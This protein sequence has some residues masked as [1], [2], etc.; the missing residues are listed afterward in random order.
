MRSDVS[1]SLMSITW[2]W[3][4]VRDFSSRQLPKAFKFISAMNFFKFSCFYNKSQMVKVYLG[5][6]KE[7]PSLLGPPLTSYN[8]QSLRCKT[9]CSQ[10]NKSQFIKE[11]FEQRF[12][13]KFAKSHNAFSDRVFV[14]PRYWKIYCNRIMLSALSVIYDNSVYT[15]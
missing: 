8:F 14:C 13:R 11:Y 7:S 15:W 1:L 2:S 6:E 10:S 9:W 4:C 3:S 5:W 12:E